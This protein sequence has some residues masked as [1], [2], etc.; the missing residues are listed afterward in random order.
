MKAREIGR[1][2]EKDREI[3]RE[4]EGEEGRGSISWD[5]SWIIDKTV[6]AD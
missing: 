4:K 3:G 1:D 5:Y 2:K 6:D